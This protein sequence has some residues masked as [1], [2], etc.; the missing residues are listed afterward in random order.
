MSEI[1][2]YTQAQIEKQIEEQGNEPLP[3]QESLL[4]IIEFQKSLKTIR[5]CMNDSLHNSIDDINNDFGIWD[6]TWDNS[7]ELTNEINKFNKRLGKIFDLEEL[8]L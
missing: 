7:D 4:K 8:A 1:R 5:K 2:K 3:S 6:W